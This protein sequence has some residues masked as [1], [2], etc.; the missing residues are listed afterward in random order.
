MNGAANVAPAWLALGVLLH[1]G[2]QVARGCGW[3]AVVRAAGPVV[4]RRDTIAGWG[5]GAGAG[6]LVA[7]RGGDAVRVWVLARRAP[8]SP[9]PVLTGTLVAEAAGEC[10]LGVAL[11]A[12]ALGLGVGPEL[13]LPGP[14]VAGIAVA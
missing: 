9:W 7:A 14:A 6:G 11:V 4:R 1:L 10:L 2:N 3:G 5:A 12:A 8:G 13:G